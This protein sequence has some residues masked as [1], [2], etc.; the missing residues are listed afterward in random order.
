MSS[1]QL[2]CTQMY[3]VCT[4]NRKGKKRYEQ[5]HTPEWLR[6]PDINTHTYKHTDQ[7]FCYTTSLVHTTLLS[8]TPIVRLMTDYTILDLGI[9]G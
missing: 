1:P 7:P 2:L 4:G 9:G 5:T 8:N 6:Q 3:N